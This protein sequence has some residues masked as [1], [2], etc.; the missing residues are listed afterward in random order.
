MATVGE[1]FLLRDDDDDG[2]IDGDDPVAP[3]V[4]A[5]RRVVVS[6]PIA[7]PARAP[8]NFTS[9]FATGQGEQPWLRGQLAPWHMWG[10]QETV[11][12]DAPGFGT[13]VAVS[14]QLTKVSYKRPETWHWLF[15]A[16]LISAPAAGL[17]EQAALNIRFD[18]TIGLG[19]TSVTI[20][21]F[22]FFSWLWGPSANPPLTQVLWSVSSHAPPRNFNGLVNN[23]NVV[24]QIVAQDIQVN[25][26]V[27][28][29]SS[30]AGTITAEVASFFAP[31]NHIR[32]DWFRD[33]PAEATFPGGEVGGT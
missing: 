28:N 8:Q 5:A 17:A 30:F 32:P 11:R 19:R 31:K 25:A 14:Q 4:G 1:G 3:F 15:F 6:R 26:V 7:T 18:V 16:R 21:F 13:P 23:P 27:S 10:T 33:A 24:D 2:Q 12:A 22:E 29:N 9:P 20:P